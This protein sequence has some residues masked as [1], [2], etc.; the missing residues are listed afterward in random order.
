MNKLKCYT[1]T[2]IL[3]VLA[4]GILLHF[5]YEWSGNN[6]IIGFYSAVNESTW[7]HMKLVFFPMLLYSLYMN[8]KLFNEYPCVTAALLSGILFGTLLIPVIFYTYSG[9]L[10]QN[11]SILNISTFVTGVLI[12]FFAVYKWSISCGLEDFL[13]S[14]VIL[15]LC[16]AV[17]FLLFTYNP[18]TIGIFID[19]TK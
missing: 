17:C 8:K 10:G 9:I 15:V 11:L 1:I 19:P 16:L 4:T 6:R 14:L 7:E 3:F 2:G 12:S 5:A 18:P 13:D